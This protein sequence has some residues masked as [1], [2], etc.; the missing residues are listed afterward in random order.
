MSDEDTV[1]ELPAAAPAGG[2]AKGGNPGIPV[3]AILI[4]LPVLSFMMT[5]FVLIPKIK[6]A[7]AKQ[8]GASEHASADADAKDSQAKS[9]KKKSGSYGDDKGGD[10]GG[11]GSANSYEFDS[12][13]T[14]LAGSL[15]S[16]YVKVSFTVEGEHPGFVDT[17]ESNKAKLIDTTLGLLS[18]LSLS[19]LENPGIKNQLRSDLIAAYENALQERV[20]TQLYFSEFVVQ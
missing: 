2:A 7:V 10:Y 14:N 9:D 6:G 1:E 3:L 18:S 15:K 5:D 8:T 11:Y 17:I 12:I 19:D 4:L 16:R 13:I 20:I